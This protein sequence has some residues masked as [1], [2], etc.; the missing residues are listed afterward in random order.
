MGQNTAARKDKQ[1]A[2]LVWGMGM[3]LCPV[4]QSSNPRVK[5]RLRQRRSTLV[6]EGPFS[7]PFAQRGNLV[8]VVLK[9]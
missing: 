1:Q 9:V 5:E 2:A 7:V 4:E 3:A 6:V 8:Q